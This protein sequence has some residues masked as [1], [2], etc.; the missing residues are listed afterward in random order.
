MAVYKDGSK[1]TYD[2]SSAIFDPLY[3]P[4]ILA[5]VSGIYR[6]EV[7]GQECTHVS[8]RP[9]PPQN[10]HQ[11]PQNQPIMWRLLVAHQ[12]PKST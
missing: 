4:G 8:I 3:P 9:L 11:H 2:P 10:H 12:G 7:C 5:P 1:L 6:C